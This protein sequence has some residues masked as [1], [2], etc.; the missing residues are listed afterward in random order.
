[1]TSDLEEHDVIETLSAAGESS[2][3]TTTKT[4]TTLGELMKALSELKVDDAQS[5]TKLA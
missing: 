4:K 1:V 2:Q 3:F 5:S